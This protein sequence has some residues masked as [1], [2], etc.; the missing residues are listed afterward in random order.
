MIRRLPYD[1]KNPGRPRRELDQT[2]EVQT[3]RVPGAAGAPRAGRSSAPTWWRGDEEASQS[4]LQAM[5]V[6]SATGG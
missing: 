3:W 6:I 5:G 2:L 4:F 1:E